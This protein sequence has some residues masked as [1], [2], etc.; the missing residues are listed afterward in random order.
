[1]AKVWCVYCAR[2]ISPDVVG[3][4]RID[5]ARGYEPGNVVRACTGCNVARGSLIPADMFAEMVKRML[6]AGRELW[7]TGHPQSARRPA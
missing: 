5:N 4:D 1:M 2:G 6:E 7:P 3:L